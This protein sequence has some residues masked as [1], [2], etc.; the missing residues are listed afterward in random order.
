MT[1]KIKLLKYSK[2]YHKLSKSRKKKSNKKPLTFK[3]S[4]SLIDLSRLCIP[5]NKSVL[6]HLCNLEKK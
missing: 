1:T 4:I 5:R 3:K 2:S 6:N